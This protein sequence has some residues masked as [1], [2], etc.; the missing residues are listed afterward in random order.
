MHKSV[1]LKFEISNQ[2]INN[3]NIIIFEKQTDR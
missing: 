3:K 2:S 1:F